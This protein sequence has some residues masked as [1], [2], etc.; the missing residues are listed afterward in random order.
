[1]LTSSYLTPHGV[2]D[3]GKSM[4][5]F[6]TRK[7]QGLPLDKAFRYEHVFAIR[8]YCLSITTHTLLS[9]NILLVLKVEY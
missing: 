1:M 9:S 3:M 5:S 8:A 7:I 2:V 4:L 6:S